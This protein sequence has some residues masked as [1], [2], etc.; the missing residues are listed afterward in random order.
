M[1]KA[2]IMILSFISSGCSDAL[3]KMSRMNQPPSFSSIGGQAFIQEKQNITLPMPRKTPV[4]YKLN[5]LWQP[6]ARAFFKDQRAK[7]VGDI[8]NVKVSI[9]DNVD[10]SNQTTQV[11]ADTETSSIK[12]L[13]GLETVPGTGF[14]RVLSSIGGP[15]HTGTGTVVRNE[16]L[17]IK[18]A[19]I[20]T[21]SLPNG[22]LVING[23]QEIRVNN[24]LREIEI[25]GVVRR[26]DIEASNIV[27][28]EKIAEARISYGGKGNLSDVQKPRW[29]YQLMEALSPI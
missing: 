6:G 15:S 12:S 5:S 25:S 7:E 22:N 21:Q 4:S 17:N 3:E 11:R 16:T 1:R 2:L 10:F 8:L 23:K 18:L 20:I 28:Y 27:P 29:G 19:A 9:S 26:E 24:E 14:P 13:F